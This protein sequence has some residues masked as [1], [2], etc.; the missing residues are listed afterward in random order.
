MEA[1]MVRRNG[2]PGITRRPRA[3]VLAGL[4]IA[5]AIAPPALA[6]SPRTAQ[7][8]VAPASW[9][10]YFP[11]RLGD[12]WTYEWT[13]SGTLAPAGTSVR[14]RVF[15]GTSFVGDTVGYKL[16]GDDGT[17]HLYTFRRGVLSIHSSYEAGKLLYYDPAVVLASPDMVVGVAKTVT[18]TDTQRTW[19]ATVVGLTT[20]TTPVGTFDDALEIRLEMRAD[21]YTSTATHVFAPRVGL[22]AYRYALR[23]ASRQQALLDVD[24]KLKFARL[25]NVTVRTLGDVGR[26]DARAGGA[27]GD[28]PRGD[29]G[30][31]DQVK[32]AL[33]NRYTW[34][35]G[36]PGLRGDV[37]ITE[38]GKPAVTGRFEI[39]PDLSVTVDADSDVARAALRNE[40]SS[41]VT[42]RKPAAADD[43][44]NE[45]AFK[46]R[47]TRPDGTVTVVADGDPLA[48]T[49]V[50]RGDRIVEMGRTMGR[51]G[52]TARERESL[53]TADGRS[54]AVTYDVVF[55]STEDGKE[56]SVDQMRD[57]YV[58]LGA[59]WVPSARSVS[60]TVAGA[61]AAGRHV[62]L[63]N[64][65]L[66]DER[67]SLT[68]Q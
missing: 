27:E 42:Q 50:L 51:L 16:V 7:A 52:Y 68:R 28:A 40:L 24:A 9:A 62:Q 64:V 32:R 49:Y 17:Y 13:V 67:P 34:D 46:K 4:A 44:S 55:T 2:A 35:L 37:T 26:L 30:V 31:R 53:P 58:R 63:A 14:T 20:V 8:A 47:E 43:P 21:D 18:H 11:F 25:A 23:D 54:I 19:S 39:A 29:R 45:L 22:V 61:T 60:R 38:P 1:T 10:S 15:D 57:A 48:T 59:W 41:F 36:F 12:S 5:A 66:G 56:L 65:K 3:L 6:Q 33:A